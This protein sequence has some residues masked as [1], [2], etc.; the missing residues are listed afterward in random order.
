MA[1]SLVMM[2]LKEIEQM[3]LKEIEQMNLSWFGD[4]LYVVSFKG[5]GGESDFISTIDIKKTNRL[6]Y[7][8][9]IFP[10]W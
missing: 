4:N 5:F 7:R 1:C 10:L 8:I 2:N 9:T 6:K 3:N